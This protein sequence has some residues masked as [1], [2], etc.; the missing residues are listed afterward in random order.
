MLLFTRFGC[1]R[2][3]KREK[4]KRIHRPP[5]RRMS[6]FRCSCIVPADT[7]S[8]R[9]KFR[10]QRGWRGVHISTRRREHFIHNDGHPLLRK[11]LVHKKNRVQDIREKERKLGQRIAQLDRRSYK[12]SRI[13]GPAL[14]SGGDKTRIRASTHIYAYLVSRRP[15]RSY[16]ASSAASPFE[17]NC[18]QVWVHRGLLPGRLP[19][20]HVHRLAR[21]HRGGRGSRPRGGR[22]H[23]PFLL[24][25]GALQHCKPHTLPLLVE[26]GATNATIR[27]VPEIATYSSE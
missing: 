14:D 23:V 3:L 22:P 19:G 26:I 20:R 17:C 7:A 24:H 9:R 5:C 21:E 15:L 12:L 27:G 4:A 6:H 13:Q 11:T 8:N 10:T 2:D 1:R 16:T 18:F 25:T